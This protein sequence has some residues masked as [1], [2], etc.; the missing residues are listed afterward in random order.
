M[1]II[2]WSLVYFAG[3]FADPMPWAGDPDKSKD[4]QESSAFIEARDFLFKQV[5]R[6]AD[7]EQLDAGKSHIMSGYVY[8]GLIVTWAVIF[9]TLAFGLKGVT[10]V[11]AITVP[12]P[13]LLLIV[14]LVYNATLEGAQDGIVSPP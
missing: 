11:V 10:R 12:L 5:L 8:A 2:A 7:D 14:M 1:V 3:S 4:C 6:V 13:L 9:F